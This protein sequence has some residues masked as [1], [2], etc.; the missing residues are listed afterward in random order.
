M[1]AV[2]PDDSPR[3]IRVNQ[4][5]LS[6]LLGVSRAAVSSATL[7]KHYC[8]GY[9]VFNWAVMHPGG[10]QIEAYEIPIQFAKE[11]I[12]E[13]EWTRYGIFDNE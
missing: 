11:K 1:P 2:V 8:Q 5:E 7:N 6:D 4:T 3:T 10:N 13:D 9:D 12:P